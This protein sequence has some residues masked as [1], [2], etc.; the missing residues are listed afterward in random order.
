MSVLSASLFGANVV[1]GLLNVWVSRRLRQRVMTWF[2][3]AYSLAWLYLIGL[4]FT[5]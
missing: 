3:T 1:L 2:W 4:E 5:K